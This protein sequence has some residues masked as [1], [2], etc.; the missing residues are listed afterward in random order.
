MSATGSNSPKLTYAQYRERK[1]RRE[2][3]HPLVTDQAAVERYAWAKDALTKAKARNT[4]AKTL[5]QLEADV[6]AAEQAVRDATILFRLRALAREGDNSFEVLKA[7]HP[8][9]DA[10]HAAAREQSDNPKAKAE[11]H[12]ATFGPALVAACLVEPEMTVEQATAEAAEMNEAEWGGLF[13]AAV[14]VN[15]QAT[16]TA[17][18]VFS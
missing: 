16:P 15:T 6:E 13:N 3:V 4:P 5:A 10:D 12:T 1:K 17:G 11:W 8:P 18:L 2:L 7:E 9:Q 14:L